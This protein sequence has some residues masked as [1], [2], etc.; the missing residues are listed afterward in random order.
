MRTCVLRKN[1]F[2]FAVDAPVRWIIC[3]AC[4]GG[5]ALPHLCGAPVG[6]LLVSCMASRVF[7][8]LFSYSFIIKCYVKKG[9]FFAFFQTFCY[10]HHVLRQYAIFSQTVFCSWKSVFWFQRLPSLEQKYSKLNAHDHFVHHSF[11]F[12]YHFF[13]ISI[14]KNGVVDLRILH[15]LASCL[16]IRHPCSVLLCPS[17]FV[18]IFIS[19]VLLEFLSVFLAECSKSED[20][21][22]KHKGGRGPESTRKHRNRA[23]RHAR[24]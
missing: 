11:V 13:S 10:S 14:R 3:R 6:P 22:G 4:P 9:D 18:P 1:L 24:K 8:T 12:P 19:S 21:Q 5:S 20:N 7:S 16:P 2:F 23:T 15:F 17:F